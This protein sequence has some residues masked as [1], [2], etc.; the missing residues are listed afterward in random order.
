M[1]AAERALV[2]PAAAGVRNRLDVAAARIPKLSA[3]SV[4]A[5]VHD[6]E[7]DAEPE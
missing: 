7:Q 4:G 6:P 5:A 1:S 2:G 3:L